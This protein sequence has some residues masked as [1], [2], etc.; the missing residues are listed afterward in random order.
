MGTILLII[1]ILLLIGA[2]P[3][4]P[5]SRSWGLSD[6]RTRPGTHHRSH[7]GPAWTNL[8]L[9][10]KFRLLPSRFAANA[11]FTPAVPASSP[12]GTL[13]RNLRVSRAS[14][15]NG[16]RFANCHETAD[17][18]LEKRRTNSLTGAL[19]G[20]FFSGC[21]DVPTLGRGE[22]KGPCHKKPNSWIRAFICL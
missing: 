12:A 16:G 2:F 17:H 14:A 13:A 3:A 20:F 22:P 5:H 19:E 1:L 10:Q 21:P 4:W 9:G 7:F 8:V 18:L 15:A 6:R 11:T